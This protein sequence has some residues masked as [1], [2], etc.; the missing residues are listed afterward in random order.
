MLPPCSKE[1]KLIVDSLQH[2]NVVVDSVAGSGKTTTNLYIA[3]EYTDKNILLL[4]YNKKLKFETRQKVAELGLTNIE[5]HT[6]HSFCVKYY[7]HNCY[8]D[9]VIMDII[10]V[11]SKKKSNFKYDLFIL[12]ESQDMNPLYFKLICKVMK[13]NNN[14]SKI[15]ILGDKYQS[16]YSFNS[17]DPRFIIHADKL[18]NGFNSFPWVS[19][20]LSVSYRLNSQ[21]ATFIN[22]S[23]LFENR[24]K[25]VKNGAVVRYII[26]NT[27]ESKFSTYKPLIEIHRY[28][29]MG[30]RHED[31]FVIAP[32]VKCKNSPIRQLAN[33]MTNYN[34]PLYVPT[35]DDERL[36]EDILNNKIV[37][38]TYHQ[39][40]GLERK[41]VIVFGFDASY[42]QY[43]GRNCNPHRCPNE[44]YVAV[45]R[46][47]EC[48][49]IFHHYNKNF[50]QFIDPDTLPD[51][52]DFI[53][54][55]RLNI[56]DCDC[57]CDIPNNISVTNLLRHLPSLV[58]QEALTYINVSV[59]YEKENTIDIPIKTKQNNLYE[60]V[61]DINGIAIPVYYEAKMNNKIS[62][63]KRCMSEFIK[64]NDPP[65]NIR[66][67]NPQDITV[68]Q[69]LFISNLWN[70]I[71][72][73]Y[74]Y[75]L[76][77]INYYNWLN[78]SKLDEC[79]ER[80]KKYIGESAVFERPFMVEDEPELA[81]H[82]LQGDID[83]IDG[84]NIWEFK[85]VQQ[86]D[87]IHVLQ[88]ALY[89]YLYEKNYVFDIGDTVNYTHYKNVVSGVIENILS[90]GDLLISGK[91][92]KISRVVRNYYLFNILNN[93]VMKI[94]FDMEKLS[95]MVGYLIYCKYSNNKFKNDIDFISHHK[96]IA[97][98]YLH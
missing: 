40:K 31:I 64:L 36:D 49:T 44:L 55:N 8:T 59:K 65:I 78:K 94:T 77:Q 80:M 20:N 74:T 68:E 32:S 79:V 66:N 15:C 57:D 62:I 92:I 72:S 37:F 81:G 96:D 10:K 71:S 85:C 42:F 56:S 95:K 7:K 27:F 88:L 84:N 26:A 67:I 21:M 13:D 33:Q 50:L 70:T 46:A 54:S 98:N 73:G 28:I 3:K 69:L 61:S 45:T 30:Y 43:Y 60:S 82:A 47:S 90:N 89:A 4:T 11:N 25:C 6:Y 91:R 51:Y 63:Y 18:F 53:E 22:N 1:Q 14:S 17:A 97:D 29:R 39:V 48:M 23:L 41:V 83:C 93:E 5:I 87:D 16:I 2:S 35:S 38:S 58:T 19:H 75:K 76:K 34:I 86:I 12:D 24:M 9:V 52:V